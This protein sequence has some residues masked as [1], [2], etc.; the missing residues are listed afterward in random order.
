MSVLASPHSSLARAGLWCLLASFDRSD[1]AARFGLTNPAPRSCWARCVRRT[2]GQVDLAPPVDGFSVLIFI[3]AEC[4]ISN[5][6]S[7]TLNSLVDRFPAKTVKWVA[8][9]VDPDLSDA[10]VK[11]HAD[12]F[13]LKLP[14]V[15]DRHGT[16]ARKL[17]ATMTP[18]AFVIDSQR[19]HPLPRPHRR[20]VRQA[21]CAER[22]SRG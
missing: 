15:R 14:V 7:P 9:S 5:A 18:E 13:K 3:S 2:D 22:E 20:P 12:D 6:Y 1:R 11:T 4:P 21:R 16:F 8:I 10:D 19:P 17:G